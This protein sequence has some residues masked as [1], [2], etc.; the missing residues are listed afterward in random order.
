MASTLSPFISLVNHLL[1]SVMWTGLKFK[2]PCYLTAS[3]QLVQSGCSCELVRL[4]VYKCP[5][6]GPL[7]I[8]GC[9][10][11]GW[12][13]MLADNEAN[14]L[15]KVLESVCRCTQH[16]CVDLRHLSWN[17]RI[18]CILNFYILSQCPLPNCAMNLKSLEG[19]RFMNNFF[20]VHRWKSLVILEGISA[21]S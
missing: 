3:V 19:L 9:T 4:T 7:V 16:L 20:L 21:C 17:I 5:Y 15:N 1:L 18:A 14:W 8:G 6:C 13:R 12:N 2:N 10:S 11:T